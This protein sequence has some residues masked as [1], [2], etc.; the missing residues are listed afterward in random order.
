MVDQLNKAK[1]VLGLIET[2]ENKSRDD[3]FLVNE[4]VWNFMNSYVI[5]I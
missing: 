4:I 1:S 3:D 2:V 5:I